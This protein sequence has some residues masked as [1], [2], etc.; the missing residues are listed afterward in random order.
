[1]SKQGA[2]LFFDLPRAINKSA[3]LCLIIRALN[4]QLQ[5]GID[6]E[7]LLIQWGRVAGIG[8]IAFAVF[9]LLFR[10]VDLPKG[11][12]KHLTL[13]MWLVWSLCLIGITIYFL[14][15]YFDQKAPKT[16]IS[17]W[18]KGISVTYPDNGEFSEFLMEN[19]GKT[20]YL[21]PVIDMSLSSEESYQIADLI[22]YMERSTHEQAD[23]A[24]GIDLFKDNSSLSIPL[25]G[26]TTGEFLRFRLLGNRTL[27]ISFGGTGAVQFPIDGF[28]KVT[29]LAYSGPRVVYELTELPVSM[30][31]PGN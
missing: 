17:R 12:R 11:S 26:L 22:G 14:V 29:V 21:S 4:N 13:F 18:E 27:P 10:K 2:D 6:V 15:Q 9:L 5:R 23:S 30:T 16:G 28:F 24:S 25:D 31:I 19:R 20:V 1:M 7:E 8:G 3:P